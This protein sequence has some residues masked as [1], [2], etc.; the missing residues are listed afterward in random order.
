MSDAAKPLTLDLSAASSTAMV[1]RILLLHSVIQWFVTQILNHLLANV[2]RPHQHI[3]EIESEE[4][5]AV[6]TIS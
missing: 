5:W 2:V 1:Y 6:N 3:S 4:N